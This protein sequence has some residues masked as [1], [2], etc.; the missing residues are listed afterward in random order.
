MDDETNG[1]C[2]NDFAMDDISLREIEVVKPVPLIPKPTIKIPAPT[3]VVTNK[4]QAQKQ[5]PVVIEPVKP[6]PALKR[7]DPVVMQEQVKAK[8]SVAAPVIKEIAQKTIVPDVLIT[9]TNPVIK[10]IST[11][12]T[13]MQIDL[14]DNGEVDGDTVTV[15]DNNMLLVSNAGISEKPVSIKIKVDRQHPHHEVVMVA[16]NLGTIPPN[17]SLMIITA[18]EK[19]YEVFISSSKQK[20]AKIVI[21]LKE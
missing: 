20:N 17:T 7:S 6:A 14:Y 19:R 8:P 10:T 11:T 15:Y 5:N 12:A 3:T 9:R 13:E 18:N 4:P 1:G 16:N 21:D 2:G